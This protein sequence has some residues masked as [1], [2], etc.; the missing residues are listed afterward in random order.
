[1]AR[2]DS[3]ETCKQVPPPRCLWPVSPARPMVCLSSRPNRHGAPRACSRNRRASGLD[4]TYRARWPPRVA[5][6][7][8]PHVATAVTMHVPCLEPAFTPPSKTSPSSENA[9]SRQAPGS[10]PETHT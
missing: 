2:Y 4:Q 10:S 3:T 9:Y 8:D 6:Q 7:P 5:V 1:M